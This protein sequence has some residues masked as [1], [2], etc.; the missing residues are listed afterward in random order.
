V[1]IIVKTNGYFTEMKPWELKKRDAARCDAVVSLRRRVT[2]L[3]LP[4]PAAH[5]PYHP[6]DRDDDAV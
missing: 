4:V 6:C 5:C 3:A 2:M 1:D